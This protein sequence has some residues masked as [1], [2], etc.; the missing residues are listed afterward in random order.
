[1]MSPRSERSQR[2][3]ILVADEHKT[4]VKVERGGEPGDYGRM[5]RGG[6][7]LGRLEGPTTQLSTVKHM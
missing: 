7:G 5:R 1:M 3:A 4:G 2:D 6:G